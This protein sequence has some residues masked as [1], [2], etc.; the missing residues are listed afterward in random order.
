MVQYIM[1]FLDKSYRA[2]MTKDEAVELLK[3]AIALAMERDGS[4]GYWLLLAA[5]R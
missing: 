4:S 5:P 2:D 3:N 1:G